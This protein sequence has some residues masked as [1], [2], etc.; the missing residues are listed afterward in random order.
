[1]IALDF[2]HQTEL[3]L[4][5]A[6]RA[7]IEAIDFPAIACVRSC[8][9]LKEALKG[10]D[11]VFAPLFDRGRF[12]GARDQA[13]R[14]DEAGQ[15]ADRA[16]DQAV[17]QADQSPD[18]AANKR[19]F[20]V[21]AREIDTFFINDLSTIKDAIVINAADQEGDRP[22]DR[23][24]QDALIAYFASENIYPYLSAENTLANTLSLRL[25][26]IKARQLVNALK[27]DH[28]S[29]T[30]GEGCSM[31]LGAPSYVVQTY[32]FSQDEA[33]EHLSLSWDKIDRETAL[34]T[35]AQIVFRYR[36]IAALN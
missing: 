15:A 3:A 31:D 24:V 35:C 9:A 29:I 7:R 21:E 34:K 32:G 4:N 30:N 18:R 8:V 36:Q 1:M 13:D 20:V 2:L 11:V 26:K 12:I 5:E 28:I 14:A 17:N 27:L 23:T 25:P 10:K 33:R 6:D 16:G 22:A 19:R